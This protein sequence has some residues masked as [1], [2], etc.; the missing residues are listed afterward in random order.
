MNCITV[1]H[2]NLLYGKNMRLHQFGR[3]SGQGCTI[4]SQINC[5]ASDEAFSLFGENV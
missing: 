4:S 3:V 1:Y 2:N 5:T